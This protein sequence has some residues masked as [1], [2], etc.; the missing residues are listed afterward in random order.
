[1]I[2][3]SSH[4]YIHRN[5]RWHALLQ[6]EKPGEVVGTA[7]LKLTNGEAFNTVDKYQVFAVLSQRICLEPALA[8]VEAINLADRSVAH[9]MRLLTGFSNNHSLF[10]THTPSEPILVLGAIR[11]LYNDSKTLGAALKT[12]SADLCSAG[13]VNKSLLGELAARILILTARDYATRLPEA[14]TSHLKPMRLL[15]VLNQ[16]FGSMTWADRNQQAFNT[17]FSDAYVNFTHWIVT[18]EPLP[19]FPTRCDKVIDRGV[20]SVSL[21]LIRKLLANFWARGAALQCCFNQ[22]SIDFFIV[23]YFG[24][25]MDGAVFDPDLLSDFVV[26]VKFKKDAGTKA[27]RKVR[28]GAI[29]SNGALPYLALLMEFDTESVHQETSSKICSAIPDSA[30]DDSQFRSRLSDWMTAVSGLAQ[31]KQRKTANQAHLK[32][33][34]RN[35]DEKRFAMDSCNR[36]SIAIRGSSD[37][38]YGILKTAQI[39]REFAT[40]LRTSMPA[41]TPPESALQHMRPSEQLDETSAYMDWMYDYVVDRS[42]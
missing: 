10:Y 18:R 17:A 28:R 19:E 22:S 25:V 12:L 21:Q 33:L 16:L 31:E 35:V 1:L 30:S 20:Y 41:Y 14:W 5:I 29:P 15:D 34:Q 11:L 4:T 7:S 32:Q 26:Q 9:H 37:E 2:P 6:R 24:S 13:L 3:I 39:A 8:G 38:V 40:L 42:T 23:V 36:Y 27:E